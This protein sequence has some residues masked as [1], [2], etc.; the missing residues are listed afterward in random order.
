[1]TEPTLCRRCEHLYHII[2]TDFYPTC[3]EYFCCR[4]EDPELIGFVAVKPEWCPLELEK[5]PPMHYM[6]I[7][8]NPEANKWEIVHYT[9][10]LED[11]QRMMEKWPEPDYVH[12]I[13]L[14]Y[15]KVHPMMEQIQA[16]RQK[17][18]LQI[19]EMKK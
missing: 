15:L 5:P 8:W 18:Q 1:M 17:A 7:K 4:Y 16:M 9:H 14:K 6:I 13:D 19:Q 10:L 12:L 2:R 3:A 11:M